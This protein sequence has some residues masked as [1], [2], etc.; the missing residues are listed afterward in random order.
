MRRLWKL[1]PCSVLSIWL[2]G[3]DSLSGK[4]F[5][6]ILNHLEN[7]V[8]SSHKHR[9]SEDHTELRLGPL[10]L[11][12]IGT[13][14]WLHWYQWEEVRQLGDLPQLHQ[15]VD[16]ISFEGIEWCYWVFCGGKNTRQGIKTHA[17]TS[18]GH[19]DKPAASLSFRS[20][21]RKMRWT[22]FVLS[23]SQGQ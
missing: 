16:V 3:I 23:A 4:N 15:L 12:L 19:L 6:F 14:N 7:D 17:S 2:L 1:L 9:N 10:T 22:T 5:S 13:K 18:V 21:I 8:N 11:A 20:L